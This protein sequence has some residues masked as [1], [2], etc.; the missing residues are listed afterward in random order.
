MKFSDF[1]P[2][3]KVTDSTNEYQERLIKATIELSVILSNAADYNT[4]I[5]ATQGYN[6]IMRCME[7][8]KKFRRAVTG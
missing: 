8:D 1:L 5:A 4:Q 6:A 2:E 7:D 3:T